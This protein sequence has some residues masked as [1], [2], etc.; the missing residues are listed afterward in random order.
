MAFG[1]PNDLSEK[2]LVNLAKD[3]RWQRGEDVGT[4]RIVNTVE[5]RAQ[6]FVIYFERKR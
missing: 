3:I 6:Q 4:F 5:N 2:L 1:Q